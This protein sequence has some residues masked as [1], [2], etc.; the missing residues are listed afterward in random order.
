MRLAVLFSGSVAFSFFSSTW[1]SRTAWRVTARWAA[2]PKRS[3]SER[4]ALGENDGSS[5]P[6][7]AFAR[8]IRVTASSMRDIGTLPL[9]TTLL[10]AAMNS[11]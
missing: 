3:S 8:R 10:S 9:S 1:D 11:R 2:D 6:M 4:S 5:R 7:A